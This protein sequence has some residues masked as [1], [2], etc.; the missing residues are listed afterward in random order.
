MRSVR[1][2]EA[3]RTAPP[4]VSAGPRGRAPSG[5]SD[6]GVGPSDSAEGSMCPSWTARQQRLMPQPRLLHLGHD[7]AP[8]SK[9]CAPSV[10]LPAHGRRLC[11]GVGR[12]WV[13]PVG[14]PSHTALRWP[15]LW[16]TGIVVQEQ[17]VAQ[18]RTHGGR[19]L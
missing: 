2:V 3:R 11:V 19:R 4:L 16:G 9:Q 5:P 12:L 8:C 18:R 15:S 6:L 1:P 14:P 17:T 7:G 10:P 13:A